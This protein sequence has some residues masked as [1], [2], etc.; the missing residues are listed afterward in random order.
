[1]SRV[2][3]PPS[4]LAI[5]FAVLLA[6]LAATVALAFVDADRWLPGTHLPIVLALGLAGCKA[7]L[8]VMYFMHVRGGPSRV[9]M[10]AAA[11]FVW[12]GILASLT[13]A[14]YATRVPDAAPTSGSAAAAAAQ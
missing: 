8:I 6:L 7:I 11:G 13:L 3:I 9:V 4:F 1:M 14:E 10:F 12:L 2:A 5:I